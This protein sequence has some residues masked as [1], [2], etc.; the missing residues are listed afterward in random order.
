M[1]SIVIPC[2]NSERTLRETL[3]SAF[4]Q[5]VDKEIIV[6]DDGSTDATPRIIASY[7]DRLRVLT[8]TNRGVSA[9]RN[10]GTSLAQGQFIQ[11]LDSDDLLM[12]GTLRRRRDALLSS[13]ADVAHTDWQRLEQQPDGSFLAG[14]ITSPDLDAIANDAEAAT[15]VSTFWAPPAALLYRRT[16]VE[17]IGA[18]CERLPVNEDARFLF[19]AAANGARFVHVPGVG[20]HYR[21]MQGTLSRQSLPRFI[22]CCSLNTGEIEALWRS[23][24]PLPPVRH[25]ALQSMWGYVAMTALFNGFPE[26]ERARIGCSLLGRRRL[27]WEAGHILR[28]LIGPHATARIMQKALQAKRS[29]IH[30]TPAPCPR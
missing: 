5:D 22:A 10:S 25:R 8:T 27:V 12:P 7:G 14:A 30:Q 1:I 13:S 20:A 24:G 3:D 15:A 23:N 16:I 2:Y 6:V 26:F 21:V 4:A 29:L 28:R 18:W 19:D 9:A 11:Y 17:R